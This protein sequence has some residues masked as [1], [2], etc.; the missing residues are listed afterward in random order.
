MITKT[1]KGK[2]YSMRNLLNEI[3][4]LETSKIAEI[5]ANESADFTDKWLRVIE[6]LAGRDFVNALSTKTF[7]EVVSAIEMNN[8]K[9]ELQ[10]TIEVNNR[11]YKCT[12]EDEEIE[13]TARDLAKIENLAKKGGAWLHKAYA[14]VYKDVLLTDTEHYDDAHIKHK[15]D[16]FGATVTAEQCSS[17]IFQINKQIVENIQQLIDAQSKTV[18]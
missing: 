5:M 18:S 8:V 17:V 3:T 14:V 16:I 10:D 6:M 1:I 11:I 4:L 15:A 7:V 12:I 9:F 13:L 2:E